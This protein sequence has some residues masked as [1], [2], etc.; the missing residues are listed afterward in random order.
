M[1]LGLKRDLFDFANVQ[2]ESRFSQIYARLAETRALKTKLQLCGNYS[3]AYVLY[4]D[5]YGVN[6]YQEVIWDANVI[7]GKNGLRQFSLNDFDYINS[8]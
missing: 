7:Y 3:K 2:A 6:T 1:F 8:K 5:F 4:C